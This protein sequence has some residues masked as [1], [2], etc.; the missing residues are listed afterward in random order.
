MNEGTAL[1]I[2]RQIM[3]ERGFI[4]SYSVKYRHFQIAPKN[5][6]VLK[7]ENQLIFLIKPT[8]YMEVRSITG[9]FNRQDR[10]VNELQYMHTGITRITNTNSRNF[11]NAYILQVIPHKI[12]KRWN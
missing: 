9:F 5:E 1:E 8:Y 10:T 3:R 12:E 4:E 6:V 2:A 11:T 7:A